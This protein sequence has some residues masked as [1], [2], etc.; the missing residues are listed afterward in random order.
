MDLRFF[1]ALN[2]ALKESIPSIEV[3]AHIHDPAFADK[4]FDVL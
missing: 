2:S 1:E 3:N 4:V